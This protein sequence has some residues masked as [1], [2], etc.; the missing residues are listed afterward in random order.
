MARWPCSPAS[1]RTLTLCGSTVVAAASG[2][3][4]VGHVPS[5][6]TELGFQ[7]FEQSSHH[8]IGAHTGGTPWR[9]STKKRS[10][11]SAAAKRRAISSRSRSKSTTASTTS[12][13]A[14]C[15]RSTSSSYSA[16]PL[17]DER[18]ALVL[19]L[20][21]GDLV[22]VHRVDRRLRAHHRDLGGREARGVASGSNAGPAHR[23]E[24]RRRTPCAR[25]PRSSGTVAS[26]TAVII[27]APWRMMPSRSTCGADH[28][29]RARRR[30][31][32][33]AR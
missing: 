32:A 13:A 21:R 24:A 18:R 19:V 14:R 7:N 27:L 20:D 29:A 15:T 17:G 33:A 11:P 1:S 9:F 10:R 26:A 2:R 31:T 8:G 22:G 25:S 23:V 30:G 6:V 3:P 12:S 4:H 28:E 5:T 16:P